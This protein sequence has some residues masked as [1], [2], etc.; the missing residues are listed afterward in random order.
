VIA[1]V[2]T[3][4]NVCCVAAACLWVFAAAMVDVTDGG[5]PPGAVQPAV[6]VKPMSTA[7]LV[8]DSA[9]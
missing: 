9:F 1:G 7:R 5:G 8:S 6:C 3:L 2:L 4:D